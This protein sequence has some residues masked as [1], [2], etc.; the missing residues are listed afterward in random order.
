MTDKESAGADLRKAP[1]E[2][3]RRKVQGKE[4][5]MTPLLSCIDSEHRAADRSRI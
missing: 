4:T 3:M 2:F 1:R 5:V